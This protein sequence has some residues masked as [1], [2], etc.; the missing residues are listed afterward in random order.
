[1]HKYGL[2]VRYLGLMYKKIDPKKAP[3]LLVIV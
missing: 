2:N 1:M 3:N